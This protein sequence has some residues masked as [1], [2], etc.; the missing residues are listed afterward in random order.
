MIGLDSMFG[1]I[2]IGVA[3]SLAGMLWPFQRGTL[4]VLA[5]FALGVGGAIAAAL[6][7]FLLLPGDHHTP[8]RLASAAV[9][10]LVA[11]GIAHAVWQRYTHQR[12]GVS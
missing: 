5:N 10:A 1:W 8:G 4:G 11:L 7:S 2:A 12:Q 6:L 9:G 3:A